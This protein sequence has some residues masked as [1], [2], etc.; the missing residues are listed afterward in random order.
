[1]GWPTS[2]CRCRT[3]RGFERAAVRRPNAGA[4]WWWPADWRSSDASQF[5]RASGRSG[6]SPGE[7]HRG[8]SDH[9][10]GAADRHSTGT[11]RTETGEPS[12]PVEP[13]NCEQAD[14][15]AGARLS[16][17]VLGTVTHTSPRLFCKSP[18]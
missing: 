12:Y 13:G 4:C 14:E 15:E 5:E 2:R 18:P 7:H 6:S 10:D 8:D 11:D 1:M 16:T 17:V 9:N 3:A